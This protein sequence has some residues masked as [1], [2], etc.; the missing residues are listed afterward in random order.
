MK[1]EREVHV[2]KTGDSKNGFYSRTLSVNTTPLELSIPRVRNTDFFPSIIPKYSRVLPEEYQ[3]LVENI[4][5]SSKS[6]QSLKQTLSNLNL[7]YS[8]EEIERIVDILEKEFQELNSR[9]LQ[10]DWIAIFVDA[11]VIDVKNEKGEVKKATFLT[12]VGVDM[13]GKKQFLASILVYGNENLDAW[14]ELFENL[15]QRGVR[16]VL[17]FITDDFP[18]LHKVLK[19]FFSLSYHQLCIVH[20]IRRAKL[21]LK[22]ELFK[23]FKELLEKMEKANSQ[24]EAKQILLEAI[25][26]I[27]S[28]HPHFAEEIKSKLDLYTNF[29]IFYL[30]Q[31]SPFQ[32]MA[33]PRPLFQSQPREPPP[34][35]PAYLPVL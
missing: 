19:S 27:K 22:K 18:G 15:S 31:K 26:S 12:A 25:E 5:I 28:H 4:L 30:H 8:P 29:T 23:N 11:K 17:I 24:D 16:R 3:K 14:K 21:R 34:P 33:S 7:P 32:K 13:D 20:L 2:E 1:A 35:L 6:I 10:P 9:E